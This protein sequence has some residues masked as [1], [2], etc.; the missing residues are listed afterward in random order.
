MG[1]QQAGMGIDDDVV[2]PI[3]DR[4]TALIRHDQATIGFNT[5]EAH[6]TAAIRGND[7]PPA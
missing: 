6:Q 5:H 1:K 2:E 7:L 3:E 4:I